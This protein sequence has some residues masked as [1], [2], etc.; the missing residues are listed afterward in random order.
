M[1]E[2][3]TLE[4]LIDILKALPEGDVELMTH[5]GHL[6]D[7]LRAVSSYAEPRPRELALLLDPAVRR[8]IDEQGI[9][10]ISFAEL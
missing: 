4:H 1:R 2:G 10:L 3:V 6:D 9:T 5:P 8:L 7:S